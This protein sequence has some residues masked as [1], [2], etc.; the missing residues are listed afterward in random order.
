MTITCENYY[1][2]TYNHMFSIL[3]EYYKS[4]FVGLNVV[5]FGT[6]GQNWIPNSFCVGYL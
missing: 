1:R 4:L 3:Y 5:F 2:N 6:T